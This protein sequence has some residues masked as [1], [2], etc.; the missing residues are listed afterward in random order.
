MSRT[1]ADQ[2]VDKFLGRVRELMG[3]VSGGLL[4][5]EL[6][7]TFEHTATGSN[8]SHPRVWG[9]CARAAWDLAGDGGVVEIDPRLNDCA[10]LKFQPDLVVRSAAKVVL[11]AV[12]IESPNSS[13]ARLL[14]KDVDA[15]VDWVR[16]E[17]NRGREPFP[18]LVITMLP[19][20]PREPDRTWKLRWSSGY[21]HAQAGRLAEICA[22]PYRFW[23]GLLA[24]DRGLIERHPLV[25]A[26]F[27]GR[28]LTPVN[29]DEHGRSEQ[30]PRSHLP[31]AAEVSLATVLAASA[32]KAVRFEAA[33]A[34]AAMARDSVVD[35]PRSKP[36]GWPS[37]DPMGAWAELGDGFWLVVEWRDEEHGSAVGLGVWKKGNRYCWPGPR[38]GFAVDAEGLASRVERLR[39]WWH[40]G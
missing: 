13:D 14:P 36:V 27:N 19:D 24:H 25:F 33:C 3:L 1:G 30:A 22:N 32:P 21:N 16:G 4:P 8:F 29:W 40:A 20:A 11:L 35:A 15:Y 17:R 37:A 26:N 23:Y 34:L 12:D 9:V 7:S 10:G 18:Y 38:A 2:L 31:D 28:T 39:S 5:P 6:F